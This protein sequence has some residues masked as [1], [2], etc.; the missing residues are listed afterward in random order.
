MEDRNDVFAPERL[1]YQ[2]VEGK[3]PLVFRGE[4]GG[5]SLCSAGTNKKDLRFVD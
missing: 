3:G 5:I 1:A 2:L 4:N